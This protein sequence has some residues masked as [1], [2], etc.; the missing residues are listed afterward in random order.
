ML[1]LSNSFFLSLIA[2][3]TET[4]YNVGLTWIDDRGLTDHTTSKSNTFAAANVGHWKDKPQPDGSWAF[5]EDNGCVHS[6]TAEKA[7]R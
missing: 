3:G 2:S 6:I 5:I 7:K 4:R 1:E